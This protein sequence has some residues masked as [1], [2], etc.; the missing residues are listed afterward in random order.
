MTNIKSGENFFDTFIMYIFSRIYNAHYF[1]VFYLCGHFGCE[2]TSLSWG[3]RRVLVGV[4][5]V[6]SVKRRF[7]LRKGLKIVISNQDGQKY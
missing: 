2:S 4:H 5:G 7:L 1:K 6:R 3:C